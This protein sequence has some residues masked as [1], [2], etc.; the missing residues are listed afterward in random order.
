M[1]KV[2]DLVQRWRNECDT[3]ENCM[4]DD[5]TP[6]PSRVLAIC[7]DDT[8][9][10]VQLIESKG[11]KGRYL[12]LSHC[13][14]SNEKRPLRT[15]SENY[16]IHQIGIP[17]GDLP[18]TFQDTVEFAQGIGIR[19]VWIDSLCIIQGN[20]QDWHSEAANMGDVYWNATLVVAASGAKDSSKGLFISDRPLATV[21][22]LPYRV[23][24]ECKGTFNMIQL[25]R[26]RDREP[27]FGPLDQRAWTLQ[28]RYLGQRLVTFMPNCISWVCEKVQVTESGA[29]LDG[30]PIREDNWYSLL[31]EYTRRSLSFA[32]D[33][34][35]AIRGIATFNQL[36]R[37][38][39]YVPE[40]GAQMSR[41]L[42][43]A[44]RGYH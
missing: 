29:L 22:R 37:K 23:G 33:R 21:L 41:N 6:M 11:Q 44:C 30:F 40:Y 19:Y 32:S 25:P 31:C 20:S 5:E 42:K 8:R 34:V 16:H 24:G 18:K 7:G 3:H 43:M 17:F 12:A 10:S 36:H 39:R 27:R 28:E 38:D 26:K 4:P 14:G 9:P 13:W 1:N 2:C 15:T 35:E